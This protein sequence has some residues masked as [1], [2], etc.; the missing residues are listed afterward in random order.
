L[1]SVFP[2]NIYMAAQPI[3]AGAASIAPVHG[4]F[5]A[6]DSRDNARREPTSLSVRITRYFSRLVRL[7][8]LAPD[9]HN[10]RR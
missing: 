10:N 2:A 7:S 6:R 4:Y 9:V 1:I 5:R 8:A 3:D